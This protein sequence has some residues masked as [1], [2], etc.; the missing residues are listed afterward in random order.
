MRLGMCTL[1]CL[2][3]HV[4]GFVRASGQMQR[5]YVEDENGYLSSQRA[6][7]WGV[8]SSEEEKMKNVGIGK[9]GQTRIL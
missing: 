7:G 3:V 8:V 4:F 1:L 6:G 2:R 9:R 5:A